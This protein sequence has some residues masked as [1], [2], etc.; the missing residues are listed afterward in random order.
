MIFERSV[1]SDWELMDSARSHDPWVV[2]RSAELE[3]R[4]IGTE[5]LPS[6]AV[7]DSAILTQTVSFTRLISILTVK[8]A[9]GVKS[10]SVSDPL[11]IKISPK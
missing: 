5:M 10:F 2:I 11:R 8:P 9:R 3:P 1:T 4:V 7:T 6:A